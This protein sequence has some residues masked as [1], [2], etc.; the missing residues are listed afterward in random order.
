MVEDSV[1][2]AE[3][4]LTQLR[5]ADLA[6]EARRV[7]TAEEYRLELD[8]FRPQVILSDFSM[9]G[10]SGLEALAI[11]RKSHPHIP[12]IFV[13]GTIGEESAIQAL[14]NGATDYVLKS[15]LLRLPSAVERAIEGIGPRTEQLEKTARVNRIL[16]KICRQLMAGKRHHVSPRLINLLARNLGDPVDHLPHEQLSSRELQ[17]LLL[18]GGGQSVKQIAADLAISVNTVNTHRARIL[19]KMGMR[20]NA[21]LIRYTMEHGLVE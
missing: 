15:N 21:A 17:I 10:F 4:V 16:I 20:T 14:K 9:P 11:S 1:I 13:S 12:F 18:I 5:S 3:L 7:Q 8:R 19:K 2:D 6:I